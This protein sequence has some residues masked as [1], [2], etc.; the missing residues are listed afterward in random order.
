[1]GKAHAGKTFID[2]LGGQPGKVKLDAGGKGN[3]T[4]AGGSVAVWIEEG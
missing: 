2:Y 3:F 1:M 4:V